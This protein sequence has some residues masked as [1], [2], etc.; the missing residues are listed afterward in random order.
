[1]LYGHAEIRDFCQ[2]LNRSVFQNELYQCAERDLLAVVHAVAVFQYG[3][4]IVDGM[5]RRKATALKT[6]AA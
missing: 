2:F 5:R 3:Q 6:D 4:A 1:M